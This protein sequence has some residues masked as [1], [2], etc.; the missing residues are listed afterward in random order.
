MG[1]EL[2]V[3]GGYGDWV[4][5]PRGDE[6]SKEWVVTAELRQRAQSLRRVF[7]KIRVG[8][9]TRLVNIVW[10]GVGV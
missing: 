1:L 8:L 7:V 10:V 6:E 9:Q 4:V 3:G 5:V 2:A